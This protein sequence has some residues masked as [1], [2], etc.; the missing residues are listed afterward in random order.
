M[1]QTNLAQYSIETENVIP[2][3]ISSETNIHQY[4]K[5]S[6]LGSLANKTT[7][8][9]QF[10]VLHVG[11]HKTATTY[12]QTTASKFMKAFHEDN[13]DAPR[14][15]SHSKYPIAHPSFASCFIENSK[16]VTDFVCKSKFLQ[17]GHDVIAARHRNIFISA[18]AFDRPEVDI[19]ALKQYLSPWEDVRVVV[20]YRRFYDW[21]QSY[22]NQLTKIS[23]YDPDKPFKVFVEKMSDP[24]WMENMYEQYTTSVV[25]RYKKHF[26]NVIVVNYHDVSIDEELDVAGNFFCNIVPEAAEMCKY[27]RMRDKDKTK[28]VNISKDFLVYEELAKKLHRKGVLHIQ[29][30]KDVL[31]VAKSLERHNEMREDKADLKM[32]C[33]P[34]DV[35]EDLLERSLRIEKELFPD[36]FA[37]PNGE[38]A[39]R[40]DFENQAKT[41]LCSIDVKK[42]LN[43][44]EWQTFFRKTRYSH[45]RETTSKIKR[46]V[47]D[48]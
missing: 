28:Y 4:L 15:S 30:S 46:H 34:K 29:N 44:L 18:E 16:E 1:Y 3:N 14:K 40:S 41:K 2:T 23:T 25:E 12:I 9:A 13:Y 47:P 19:Q 39:L 24:Q 42:M 5:Y 22:Y 31:K 48:V 6:N 38:A 45:E 37:S 35:L 10:A 33:L 36:F 26:N 8:L 21:L 17:Y 27:M 7:N 32:K 11:P 43:N 20:Y